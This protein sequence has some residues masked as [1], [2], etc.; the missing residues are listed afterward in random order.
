M[1]A[2]AVGRT[3]EEDWPGVAHVRPLSL[4]RGHPD[5]PPQVVPSSPGFRVHAGLQGQKGVHV[6]G[7]GQARAPREA[8][9][10]PAAS[11]GDI[12]ASDR[13]LLCPAGVSRAPGL[14]GSPCPETHQGVV[15]RPD[16]EV[17]AAQPAPHGHCHPGRFAPQGIT[18]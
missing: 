1:A 14:L 13:A 4:L 10:V 16:R 15:L 17:P 8:G 18:A 5:P 6:L 2:P 12:P 3:D 7:L 11:G 9:C